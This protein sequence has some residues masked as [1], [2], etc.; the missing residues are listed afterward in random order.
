MPRRVRWGSV[1]R[2][3]EH[4][5]IPAEQKSGPFGQS[6]RQVV[7][8][9]LTGLL[10]EVTFG[11]GGIFWGNAIDEKT[12]RGTIPKGKTR[13]VHLPAAYLPEEGVV[14]MTMQIY[15]STTG[16]KVYVVGGT[17][18]VRVRFVDFLR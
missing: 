17:S 8:S 9:N 6:Y 18:G 10:T 1:S 7:A 12:L 16:K 2:N 11:A 13:G 15:L 4:R 14:L 5:P 3:L